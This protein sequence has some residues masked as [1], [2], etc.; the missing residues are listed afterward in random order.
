MK[1]TW[2]A[3][4]S[5]FA[6]IGVSISV[7][8]LVV[9]PEFRTAG[10]L[11]SAAHDAYSRANANEVR[12]REAGRADTLRGRL[13]V[14]LASMRFPRQRYQGVAGVLHAAAA[15]ESTFGVKVTRFEP[16]DE[17]HGA[18]AESASIELSG[19]YR[20]LLPA[21][22]ALSKGPT[23]LQVTGL[24]VAPLSAMSSSVD[25]VVHVVMYDGSTTF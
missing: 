12:V 7:L 20:S 3:A 16:D 15:L 21:V 2:I 14:E 9:L 25:A 1:N 17:K 19:P 11:V 23:L 5:W 6:M 4:G 22:A 10:S 24:R 18:S 8:Y 13:A